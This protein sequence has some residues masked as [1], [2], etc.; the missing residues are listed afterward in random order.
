MDFDWMNAELN[1]A[2]HQRNAERGM[3]QAIADLRLQ[4]GLL[5]R[6]GFDAT[7]ATHRLLGDHRWTRELIPGPAPLTEDQI[8]QAVVD[9]YAR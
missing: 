7:Y 2:I 8:R 6:L 4:A 1:Q 5:R 3:V 9:A